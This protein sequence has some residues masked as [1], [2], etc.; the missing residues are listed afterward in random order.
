L[1]SDTSFRLNRLTGGELLAGIA[2]IALFVLL[3]LP[4][5][6][7]DGE[8]TT[9]W[10]AFSLI[11]ILLG[12]AALAGIELAVSTA[13]LVRSVVPMVMAVISV[14]AGAIAAILIIWNILDPPSPFATS[15]TDA[16]A[17]IAGVAAILIA[18]GGWWSNHRED[19]LG[20]F[21]PEEIG[22]L[23]ELPGPDPKPE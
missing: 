3:F 15:D 2:G 1:S 4:W 14:L 20:S 17:Y 23:R 10:G 18:V 13:T 9:A 11:D 5:Y 8:P 6:T 16:A 19:G 22:E 12:L 7:V 21:D